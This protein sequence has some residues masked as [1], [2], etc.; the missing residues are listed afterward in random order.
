MGFDCVLLQGSRVAGLFCA[1][2]PCVLIPFWKDWCSSARTQSPFR[3]CPVLINF[4][5]RTLF[6]SDFEEAKKTRHFS[7]FDTYSSRSPVVPFYPFFGEV[8]PNADPGLINRP[9]L[10]P[11]PP[12]KVTRSGLSFF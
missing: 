6:G 1:L 2:T 5:A 10:P 9:P 7:F 11:P 12:L 8:S 3:V 4:E